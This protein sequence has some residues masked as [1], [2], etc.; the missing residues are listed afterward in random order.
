MRGTG[1]MLLRPLPKM[2]AGA[3]LDG[4][5]I[6]GSIFCFDFWG[7]LSSLTAMISPTKTICGC[8]LPLKSGYTSGWAA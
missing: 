1:C 6:A 2:A 5:V 3:A 7:H 8:Q 4:V